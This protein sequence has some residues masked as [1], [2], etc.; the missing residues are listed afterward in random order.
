MALIT[1]P[2]WVP[3]DDTNFN[4]RKPIQTWQGLGFAG[5]P[6]AIANGAPGAPRIKPAAMQRSAPGNEICA[7]LFYGEVS[8]AQV[9][10]STIGVD[11]MPET[12]SVKVLVSGGVHVTF[13][14]RAT[15]SGGPQSTARV[16]RGTTVMAEWAATTAPTTRAVDFS[17]DFGDSITIQHRFSGSG[18]AS[19]LTQPLIKCAVKLPVVA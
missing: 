16:L 11:R 3:F 14:H 18:G 12:V 2:D 8:T 10:Y 4:E 5:N 13:S 6:I 17:V 19:Y 7:T 1:N 15:A 9:A